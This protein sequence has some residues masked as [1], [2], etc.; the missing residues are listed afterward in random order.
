M[1]SVS[2]YPKRKA[3]DFNSELRLFIK[4]VAEKPKE[5]TEI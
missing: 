5:T 3:S 4:P 1:V 2:S